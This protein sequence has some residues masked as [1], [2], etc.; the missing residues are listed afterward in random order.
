MSGKFG[1]EATT[2]AAAVDGTEGGRIGAVVLVALV[3]IETGRSTIELIQIADVPED[4]D[5]LPSVW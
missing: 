2:G 5:V 3:P 4:T 1:T